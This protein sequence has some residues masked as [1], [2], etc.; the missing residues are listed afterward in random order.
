MYTADDF[1]D[2]FIQASSGVLKKE[3][4]ME[5]TRGGLG[6]DYE[7]WTELENRILELLLP[8][9]VNGSIDGP[10]NCLQLKRNP[11]ELN[12]EFLPVGFEDLVER[13]QQ[14]ER[15]R[16]AMDRNRHQQVFFEEE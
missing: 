11:D 7:K 9:S 5:I 16:E 6:L 1:F 15:D 8:L 12:I 4:I 3:Q 10:W 2:E 13:I 14:E